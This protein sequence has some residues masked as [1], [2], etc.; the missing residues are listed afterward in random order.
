MITDWKGVGKIISSLC[1]LRCSMKLWFI[2]LAKNL[3][4]KICVE[5]K[6]NPSYF[7]VLHTLFFTDKLL[8][9]CTLLIVPSSILSKHHE[10]ILVSGVIWL[11]WTIMPLIDVLLH[12]MEREW[13]RERG[14]RGTEWWLGINRLFRTQIFP[15]FTTPVYAY[16]YS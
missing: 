2:L 3:T 1:C 13:E 12:A 16:V 15:C 10:T 8:S 6:V 5:S 4:S 7:D 11:A 9:F 14:E